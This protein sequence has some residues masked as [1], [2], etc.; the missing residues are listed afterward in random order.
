MSFKIAAL[1]MDH[2]PRDPGE[3]AVL[4]V[5]ADRADNETW[6]CWPSRADLVERSRLSAATVGR[7]L[8]ALER[9]GWVARRQR[10]NSSSVFRLNVPRLLQAAAAREKV[11]A[12]PDGFAPFAEEAQDIEN[13]GDDHSDR[14]S[15]HCDQTVDQTD[16]LNLSLTDL[17]PAARKVRRA[18]P[19]PAVGQAARGSVVAP[20]VGLSPFQASQIAADKSV[21]VGGV[22]VLAGS[23]EMSALRQ[24][25]RS[26]DAM[27]KGGLL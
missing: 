23:L 14:G 8:R 7:K 11:R 9:G 20:E 22:M 21:L 27:K 2:G 3:F 18:P 15:D 16:H 26:Q 17:K 19:L 1:V 5:L 10:F 25:L 24:S 12:L 13:K 6:V 4:L